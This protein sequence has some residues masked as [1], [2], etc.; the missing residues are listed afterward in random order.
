MS[1]DWY[2]IDA[3]AAVGIVATTAALYL[4]LV[5][6]VRIYGLRSF[7]KM[8]SYDFAG[9]VAVGSVL[10]TAISSE[11]PSL[12]NGVLAIGSL[13][14]MQRLFA[15]LRLRGDANRVDNQPVLLMRDGELIHDNLDATRVSEGDVRAKLRE[16]NVMQFS[17]VRA[18]V[19]ESTGDISVLHGDPDLF[20]PTLL[21]GV[22][23]SA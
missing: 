15:F 9:T 19:L 16:A 11:S 18:V 14:A 2:A 17:E 20:D 7:S 23:D 5:L 8:S 12:M 21:D 1:S 6:L 13:F 22:A 3:S 10:A 4:V